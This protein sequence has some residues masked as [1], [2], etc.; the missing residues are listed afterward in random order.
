MSRID[1]KPSFR[2]QGEVT[3]LG[4]MAKEKPGFAI[5][6]TA[7]QVAELKLY[8]EQTQ[9]REAAAVR[10]AD[11]NSDKIY[12]QIVV[13]GKVMATVYDSGF[14]ATEQSVPGLKLTEDGQGLALAKTR[15]DELMKAMPG[16]VIYGDFV[17]Q[18]HAPSSGIPESSLPK[19]TAR[20]LGEMAQE[21]SWNHARARMAA[22]DVDKK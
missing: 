11:Q 13:E 9:A 5:P 7:G 1:S 3:S 2:V 21:M 22:A 6:A 10:H 15:L 12:A 17:P 4:K 20:S 16:T 8:E 18:L 14:T 19:V